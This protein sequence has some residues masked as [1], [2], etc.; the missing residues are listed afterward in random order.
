METLRDARRHA[1]TP[2]AST[3]YIARGSRE[4]P[5][6][7]THLYDPPAGL[8]ARGPASLPPAGMIGIVGTRRA[9]EYGR[10]MAHDLAFDL[11]T[12]GCVVVSGLASGI[13]AAAHRGALAAGGT[14]IGVLGCGVDRV[15]P[16]I[17]RPLYASIAAR[18]LLLSEYLPDETPRK[19][20]FPQRNR[21]IAALSSA[22]VVVQ[23]G[24]KS[25]ALITAGMALDLG[26]E[27]LAVPGPADQAVS[28]G[29]NHLLREGAQVAETALDVLRE[30]GESTCLETGEIQGTLFDSSPSS[31]GAAVPVPAGR[32]REGLAA[33]PALADD[34]ARA[35]GIGVPEV[36]AMLCR[37]ELGGVVRSLPGHRFELVRRP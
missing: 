22:L 29:V 15:Y 23:A 8:Y 19:H 12:V 30:L 26:R 2:P 1:G 27:V 10:R 17:N 33:G 13:D 31:S 11:A 32:L 18:G 20:H 3:R 37:M 34:L 14:T 7:L 9:T 35:T 21:I 36:L 28:R 4:Y 16:K 24:E 5:E 6:R 25:G